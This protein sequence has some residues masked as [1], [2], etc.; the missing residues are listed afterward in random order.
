LQLIQKSNKDFLMESE[1]HLR[2]LKADLAKQTLLSMHQLIEQHAEDFDLQSLIHTIKPEL[3]NS[4]RQSAKDARAS[5]E[6]MY[7]QTRDRYEKC[8]IEFDDHWVSA[9][10]VV[11]GRWV[12]YGVFVF[13]RF[14]LTFHITALD[15][16]LATGHFLQSS[17]RHVWCA[18]RCRKY[19]SSS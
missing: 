8:G 18:K 15:N 14:F 7:R 6:R 13:L 11:N 9:F 5:Y 4:Q 2:K 16:H 1:Y 19:P 3:A 17:R 10:V 12:Y